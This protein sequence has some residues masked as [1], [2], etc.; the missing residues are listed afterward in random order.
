VFAPRQKP[1]DGSKVRS[2]FGNI[3][4]PDD[5]GLVT[6]DRHALSLILGRRSGPHRRPAAAP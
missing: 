6:I 1:W 2:F 3:L 5:P 4:D